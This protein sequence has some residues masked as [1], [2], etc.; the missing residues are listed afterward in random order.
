M[1]ASLEK[2]SVTN[3]YAHS[4]ANVP[5]EEWQPLQDH[6]KAV[7]AMSA[8]FAA[9]FASGEHGR[10]L[11]SLHDLGKARDSF[12]SYQNQRQRSK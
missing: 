5:I 11:G 2:V 6:C 9:P 1:E 3:C 12:Q 8:A 10:T 4:R 7:A